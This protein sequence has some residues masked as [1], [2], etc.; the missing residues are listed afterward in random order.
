MRDVVLQPCEYDYRDDSQTH[1]SDLR[2]EILSLDM[3]HMTFFVKTGIVELFEILRDTNIGTLTLITA[4]CAL[5]ASVIL[6][7]LKSL[8]NLFLCGTYGERC[9]LQL[10]ETL[11]C[12]SLQTVDCS[13]VWLC[14][15]LIALSSLDHSVKCKLLDVVMQPC[16]YSSG[17]D[18]QTHASDLR[19]EILSLDMSNT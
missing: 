19:S 18:F 16:E 1:E 2:S 3:S 9:S 7:F 4:E 15:L 5:L 11:Q 13:A 12:I 8:T 10:P 14:S 6:C 17:D